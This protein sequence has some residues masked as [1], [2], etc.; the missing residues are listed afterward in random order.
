[1]KN[2]VRR[3][4]FPLAS[5]EKSKFRTLDAKLLLEDSFLLFINDLLKIPLHDL[6]IVSLSLKLT[7]NLF[8]LV[9]LGEKLTLYF[10]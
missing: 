2:G 9:F 8:S 6:S 7:C 10:Y 4:N 5:A 1:M 3:E